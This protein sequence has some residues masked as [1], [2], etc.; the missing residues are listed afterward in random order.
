MTVHRSLTPPGWKRGR[1]YSHGV[2]AKGRLV[3]VAGQIGWRRRPSTS[4]QG[5]TTSNIGTALM[6]DTQTGFTSS[7]AFRKTLAAA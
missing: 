2:E 7:A 5:A 3:F 1:G 6:H 4:S